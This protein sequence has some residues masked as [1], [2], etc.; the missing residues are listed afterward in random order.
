MV[1]YSFL[2]VF[3]TNVEPAFVDKN[4]KAKPIE[5]RNIFCMFIEF[6]FVH[7]NDFYKMWVKSSLPFS[8]INGHSKDGNILRKTDYCFITRG[9]IIKSSRLGYNQWWNTNKTRETLDPLLSRGVCNASSLGLRKT[10]STQN[11]FVIGMKHPNM[12]FAPETTNF[13]TILLH[14]YKWGCSNS[15]TCLD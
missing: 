14:Q 7:I 9:I 4:V 8:V 12:T 10:S 13:E 6:L 2:R 3:A 1:L 15:W 5:Q 11:I